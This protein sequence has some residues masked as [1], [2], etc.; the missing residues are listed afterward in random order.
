MAPFTV[1]ELTYQSDSSQLF[2]RVRDLPCPVFLDSAWPYSERGRYDII[3]AAPIGTLFLSKTDTSSNF[4][5][6]FEKI[7]TLLKGLNPA[8]LTIDLPFSAGLI[9]SLGYD[10]GRYLANVGNQQSSYR[11]PDFY[12]GL[13]SWAFVVDHHKKRRWLVSHPDT[14]S[15]LLQDIEAR[16]AEDEKA[17]STTPFR[18]KSEFETNL[19][20]IDYNTLFKHVKSYIRA[21]DSYQINLARRFQATCEGDA[22]QAYHQLR[23]VAA[24]PWSAFLELP[25]SQILCLSP[26]RFIQVQNGQVSTAPIKG[27]APRSPIPDKDRA[28]A[29]QLAHS[30]KDRAENLMIVDLLRNDLGRCCEPGSIRVDKLFELQSFQTV[31]HLVSTIS[32]KLKAGKTALD[33]LAASFPGGSITGA[34]KRRAMEIIHELEPHDRSI[35]CGSIAYLDINGSMDSNIAIRTLLCE[36]GKIYCWSGGGIVEDSEAEAEFEE[37]WNKVG[38]LLESLRVMG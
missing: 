32:G 6:S 19:N 28:L 11:L 24:A 5:E 21:G 27:T 37:T 25:E 35:Y 12:A 10:G 34:P 31:H 17:R 38:A 3:S 36:A 33:L 18:L 1:R 23:M 9:T 30:E 16:L 22:W 7:S 2:E 4:K 26:E 20:S 15:E 8:T 14:P 29:E 13:Y